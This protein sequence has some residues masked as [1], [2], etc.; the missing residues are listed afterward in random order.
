MLGEIEPNHD[1]YDE[2]LSHTGSSHSPQLIP[3]R[4]ATGKPAIQHVADRGEGEDAS[5]AM[6]VR[7]A[8]R[9]PLRAAHALGT[10]SPAGSDW[11]WC[12]CLAA[13]V[14]AGRV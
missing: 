2:N 11:G 12:T 6:A 10:T 9:T 13:F 1:R 4:L 14:Q 8:A 7:P 5:A 3:L